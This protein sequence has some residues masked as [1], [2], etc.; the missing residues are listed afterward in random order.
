M[1][2][3]RSRS[4]NGFAADF[5]IRLAAFPIETRCLAN[6]SGVRAELPLTSY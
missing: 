5:Q 3:A 6:S 2:I 4:A 1:P